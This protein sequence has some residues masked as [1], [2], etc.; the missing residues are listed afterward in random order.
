MTV[1]E[2]GCA[3]HLEVVEAATVVIQ[4]AAA[5]RPGC[6]ISE[7]LEVLNNTIAVPAQELAGQTSGRQHLVHVQPGTMQVTYEATIAG[8]LGPAGPVS[9]EL[10]VEALRPSR[11]CP[12][13]RLRGFALTQ[14]SDLDAG[15]PRARA[16]CDFVWRH[17]AYQPE[18]SGHTTDAI[19]T[20]LAGQGVC[21]DFAHLMAALCR[22][23]EVPA[24]IASVYAPGLSPMDFHAVVETAIDGHW[25]AWD[26]SRSAPRPAMTRIATGRDA[27][28]T[29]FATVIA[30]QAELRQLEIVAVTDADLPLDDHDRL[31]MLD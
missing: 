28:D 1:R 15:A 29:A 3:L 17:V 6:A 26:P 30:G 11:Y 27:A 8:G 21:R 9:D 20:L 10:R 24:R 2:V 16:I 19:D 5:R 12:S 4:V 14:F 31:H 13:D 25:Q 18:V 23:V 7:R 22:A